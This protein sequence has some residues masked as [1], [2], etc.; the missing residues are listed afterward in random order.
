MVGLDRKT[1]K[2]E[3]KCLAKFLKKRYVND[4]DP[5]QVPGVEPG[6]AAVNP[7]LVP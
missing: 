4:N 5:I 2:V 6:G 7:S 3:S 1:E